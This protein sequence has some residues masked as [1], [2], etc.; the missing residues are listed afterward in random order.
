[1]PSITVKS[2]RAQ[3]RDLVRKVNKD[4]VA[5][6]IDG[7]RDTAV[8]ISKARYLALQEASFLLRSPELMASLRRE[9]ERSVQE[10]MVAPPA[11]EDEPAG[12]TSPSP[13]PK[14]TKSTKSRNKRKKRRKRRRAR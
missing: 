5:V 8:L 6:E 14:S 1:M 13:S 12:E 11:A 2:A 9:M 10:Q 3:L 4:T 7:K